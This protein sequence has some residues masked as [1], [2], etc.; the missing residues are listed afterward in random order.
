MQ[1]QT[2]LGS[3]MQ[4]NMQVCMTVMCSISLQIKKRTHQ[5]TAAIISLFFSASASAQ[6]AGVDICQHFSSVHSWKPYIRGVCCLLWSY[7]LPLITSLSLLELPVSG[8]EYLIIS[9]PIFTGITMWLDHH[10]SG[11]LIVTT[12][13]F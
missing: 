11:N 10:P 8:L 5:Q 9:V 1:C 2:I 6:S 7:R 4:L 12:L 13:M 3:P